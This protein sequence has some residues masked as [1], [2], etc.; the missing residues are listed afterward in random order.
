MQQKEELNI[1]NYANVA[2]DAEER[3][4]IIII[5]NSHRLQIPTFLKMNLRR[6]CKFI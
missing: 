4:R 5:S 6:I 3:G 2:G 1:Q